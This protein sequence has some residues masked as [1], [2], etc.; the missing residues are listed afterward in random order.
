[1]TRSAGSQPRAGRQPL[2]ALAG[3]VSR[4]SCAKSL[5]TTSALIPSPDLNRFQPGCRKAVMLTVR[6]AAEAGQ[7]VKGW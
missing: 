3:Y 4:I 6:L 2:S 7:A 1:M 5:V